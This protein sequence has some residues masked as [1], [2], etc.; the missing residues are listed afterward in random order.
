MPY[1]SVEASLTKLYY[2]PGSH[3]ICHLTFYSLF[4]LDALFCLKHSTS[5]SFRGGIVS[6]NIAEKYC[7]CV[8]SP[9]IKFEL[10]CIYCSIQRVQLLGMTQKSFLEVG[11]TLEHL[12][13][14]HTPLLPRNVWRDDP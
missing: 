11:H 8:I 6:Y 5:R 13:H 12:R 1:F 10:V 3:Q 4:L 9:E 7:I 2:T 14:C